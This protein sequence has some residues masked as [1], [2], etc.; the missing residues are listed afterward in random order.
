[1]KLHNVALREHLKRDEKEL[2]FD[3]RFLNSVGENVLLITVSNILL[4]LDFEEFVARV[5]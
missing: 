5:I 3:R 1:L 4:P 2:L